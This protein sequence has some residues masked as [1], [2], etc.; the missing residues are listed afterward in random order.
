MII[1]KL[2][3]FFIRQLY[4]SNVYGEFVLQGDASSLTSCL[5][6]PASHSSLTETNL[7][8]IP[9]ASMLPYK[10]QRKAVGHKALEA[11]R[12]P[13]GHLPAA[14]SRQ[15]KQAFQLPHGVA[16][17]VAVITPVCDHSWV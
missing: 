7:Q 6:E 3:E 17:Q 14:L 8:E 15:E 9:M 5:K 10:L 4:F 13:P 2:N 12:R 1:G 11:G 16:P